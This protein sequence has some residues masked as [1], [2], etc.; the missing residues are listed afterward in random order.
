MMHLTLKRLE[1]PGSLQFRLGGGGGWGHPVETGDGD[2]VW[3]VEQ[4][5]SE[6]GR[7]IKSGV[8]NKIINLKK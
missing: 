1:A 5:E 7:G 2:E 4:L 3:N 6:L 8:Q